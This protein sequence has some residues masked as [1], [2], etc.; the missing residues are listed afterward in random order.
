MVV[1]AVLGGLVAVGAVLAVIKNKGE[2]S[3]KSDTRLNIG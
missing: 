3:D 1:I 2:L